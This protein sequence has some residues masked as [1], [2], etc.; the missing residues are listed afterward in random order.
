MPERKSALGSN[1]SKLDA[2]TDEEIARQIAQDPDTAPELND[3]VLDQA[4]LYEGERFIRHGRG[5]RPKGSGT[6]ELIT[7]R[8]DRG[9]LE[10]FRA[11]G[12]GWQTRLNDL[13]RAVAGGQVRASSSDSSSGKRS[14]EIIRDLVRGDL[15]GTKKHGRVR[16]AAPVTGSAQI[17]RDLVRGLGSHEKRV[18]KDVVSGASSKVSRPP[19]PPRQEPSPAGV[20]PRGRHRRV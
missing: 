9:V 19:P 11:T 10:R 14:A 5:G 8:I 6:K 17:V 3:E 4:D 18:H 13:L 15:D 16:P 12:P 2:T 1:L 7:L 20:P